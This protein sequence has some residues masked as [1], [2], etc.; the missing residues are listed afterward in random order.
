MWVAV[1]AAALLSP[2][3]AISLAL[4]ASVAAVLACMWIPTLVLLYVPYYSLSSVQKPELF[5]QR[6]ESNTR[7]LDRCALLRQAYRP[8]PW[9]VNGHLQTLMVSVGRR[10]P[11]ITFRRE[12]LEMGDGGVVTLDWDIDY[13]E[14]FSATTPT[15]IICH[16]LTGGSHESYVRQFIKTCRLRS[17]RCVVFNY[18]GCAD[19]ELKTPRGYSAAFTDDVRAVVDHVAAMLPE[20]PLIGAGFSLGANILT[21]YMG[22]MGADVPLHCACVFANPWNCVESS[23]R[24]DESLVLSLYSRALTTNLKKFVANHETILSLRS[25]VSPDRIRRSSSIR[26]FDD[27]LTRKVFGFDSVDAYYEAAS[28]DKFLPAIAVPFLA[29]NAMDDPI[30]PGSC[31]PRAAAK[32]NPNTILVTTRH[33]GHLGWLQGWAPFEE[34]WADHAACEFID[35]FLVEHAAAAAGAAMVSAGQ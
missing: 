35:A 34:C 10:T 32:A 9:A 5:Y 27:V 4:T 21:K 16:G 17:L 23:H 20:A 25:D 31:V 26:D 11:V 2:L 7:L 30:S 22:E 13:A 19:S 12:E 15:V 29:I 28:S 18:R 33:G 8:T 6:N 1:G 24:M 14:R 3:L